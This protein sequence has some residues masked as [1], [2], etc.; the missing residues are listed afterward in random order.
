LIV[1]SDLP[2]L[3]AIA[4]LFAAL[5]LAG[6][7][8]KGPL[9]PPPGAAAAAQTDLDPA[10]GEVDPLRETGRTLGP[11]GKP[12]AAT[13]PRKRLPILDWIVD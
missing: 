7:G 10:P 2:R 9:D 5:G 8:H 12:I 3:A 1:R 4:A 11:D 13:S 6:C